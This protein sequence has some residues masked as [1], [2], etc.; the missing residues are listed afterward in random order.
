MQLVKTDFAL[1]D[2]HSSLQGVY[3][4][5]PTCNPGPLWPLWLATVQAQQPGVQGLVVD[6]STTD[7]TDFS[8]LPHGWQLLRIA[9]ADFNHGGTRNLALQH[10]P[11]GTRVVVFMTQDALLADAQ[12]LQKLV[13]ALAAPAVACAWGRQ[14]PH[15]HASLAASP[16]AA[17]ARAF[18]Y[19]ATS[20]VVGL[21][22]R[23]QWG[24]RTCFL[25]N[26]FAAYRLADLQAL[27]GFPSDVIL[28]EDMAVAARLLLAGKRVAYVAEAC[29]H[30]SHNYSLME[31]FRR[32]FDTGVFHA[33]NPWLLQT[34][35]GAGGEGQRFVRSELAYLARHAPG[36][37]PSALCRTLAKWLGYKL[38]RLEA[39]L[40]PALRRWCSMHRG[41]WGPGN[42]CRYD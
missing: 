30:H 24:L 13:A 27:G 38:G 31:E 34:F 9:A 23:G 20:R 14:L 6:S 10:V 42:S 3:L 36:W 12:A 5:V 26:S 32:Y 1:T 18:N 2:L 4:V 11:A 39:S 29:A 7:G 22:D 15:V 19:P 37:I 33:R 25:S 35:G 41:Y 28:G 8:V 16:I 17:H 21:A 40:P